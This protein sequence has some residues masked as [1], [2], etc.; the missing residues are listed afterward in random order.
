MTRRK[1]F[2]AILR[3]NYER[4]SSC[5]NAFIGPEMNFD[6]ESGDPS[7]N[8]NDRDE[9]LALT[10]ENYSGLE[11]TIKASDAK[12]TTDIFTIMV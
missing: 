11:T 5:W 2:P 12:T 8:P 7:G 1:A 4:L 10:A 3:G 6:D 9:A